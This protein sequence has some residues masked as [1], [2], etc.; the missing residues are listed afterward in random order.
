MI[1]KSLSGVVEPEEQ[2][3]VDLIGRQCSAKNRGGAIQMPPLHEALV[4]VHREYEK[5]SRVAKD[6]VDLYKK[7]TTTSNVLN[8]QCIQVQVENQQLK[9]HLQQAQDQLQ[10]L[11]EQMLQQ[12]SVSRPLGSDLELEQK[13]ELLRNRCRIKITIN[14]QC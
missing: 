11:R 10:E 4:E 3:E 12:E 9:E 14:R 5:A 7:A 13:L 2:Q 8:A 6:M 1:Q